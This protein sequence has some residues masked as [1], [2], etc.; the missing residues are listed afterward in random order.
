[1][2]TPTELARYASSTHIHKDKMYVFGGSDDHGKKYDIWCLDLSIHV[3][4]VAYA[5]SW[6]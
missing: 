5:Q 3:A 4:F 2:V 6:L 1:M